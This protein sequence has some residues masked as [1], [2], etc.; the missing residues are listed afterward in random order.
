MRVIAGVEERDAEWAET[1]VNASEKMKSYAYKIFTSI[2]RVPLLHITKP[3]RQEFYRNILVVT[4]Q[5]PL[6][7][8]PGIID[9]G[10]SIG[11]VSSHTANNISE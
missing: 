9:K 8:C 7:R 6:S 3:L 4:E 11:C 10:I 2:L 1:L 5:M